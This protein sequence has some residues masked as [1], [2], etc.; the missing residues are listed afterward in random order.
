MMKT[1]LINWINM[2]CMPP[3]CHGLNV[4]FTVWYVR[5][6]WNT[7]TGL[8]NWQVIYTTLTFAKNPLWIFSPKNPWVGLSKSSSPNELVP[9][10]DDPNCWL[11]LSSKFKTFLPKNV[12]VVCLPCAGRILCDACWS[13][14]DEA[15]N[16]GNDCVKLNPFSG[17]EIGLQLST[18]GNA[19]AKCR[20][21]VMC[22][23]FFV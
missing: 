20:K 19:S 9:S 10:N 8:V 6:S 18:A 11:E 16:A 4:L 21:T 3:A 22:L 14:G 23:I 7:S 12:D 17:L 5:G 15:P 2:L 13:M 1:V